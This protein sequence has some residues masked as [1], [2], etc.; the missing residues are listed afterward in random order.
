VSRK[1]GTEKTDW[2][3]ITDQRWVIKTSSM[4]SLLMQFHFCVRRVNNALSIGS[5]YNPAWSNPK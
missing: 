5:D 1:I 2:L 4:E 3:A